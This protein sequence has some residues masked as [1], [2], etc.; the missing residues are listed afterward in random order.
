MP[1]YKY[2]HFNSQVEQSSRVGNLF[3]YLIIGAIAI[4]FGVAFISQFI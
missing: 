1:E 2:E 4:F 3:A